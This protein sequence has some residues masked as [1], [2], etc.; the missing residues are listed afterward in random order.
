MSS[1]SWHH[2]PAVKANDIH[3]FRKVSLLGSAKAQFCILQPPGHNVPTACG[4]HRSPHAR[5]HDLLVPRGQTSGKP[6]LVSATTTPLHT[7]H[8][9]SSLCFQV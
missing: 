5:S 4:R 7:L 3:L 6:G 1:A 2:L 8:T 9:L